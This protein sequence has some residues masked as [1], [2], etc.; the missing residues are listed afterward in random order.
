MGE[1]RY[2]ALTKQLQEVADELYTRAE[3]EANEKIDYY[4]KLNDM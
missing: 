4:K 1:A 3:N 2:A